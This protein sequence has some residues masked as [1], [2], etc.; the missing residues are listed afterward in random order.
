MFEWWAVESN[1]WLML[2]SLECC[3]YWLT[4]SL[5]EQTKG[6]TQHAEPL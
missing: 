1:E 5:T 6:I 2:F 3:L 4:Y